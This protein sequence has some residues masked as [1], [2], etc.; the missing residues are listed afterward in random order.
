MWHKKI[1]SLSH[2]KDWEKFEENNESFALNILFVSYNSQEIRLLY[3]SKYNSERENK[4][5]LLMTYHKAKKCYYLVVKST[6]ELCSSEWL[7][8]KS[9]NK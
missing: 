4:V 1:D 7:K 8:K 9:C 2:L 3:K 5:V 6:L